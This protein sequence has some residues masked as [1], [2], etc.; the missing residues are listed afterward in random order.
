[1]KRYLNV[2]LEGI[3]E[4]KEVDTI[5]FSVKVYPI[6]V[7]VVDMLESVSNI[8]RILQYGKD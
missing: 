7:I 8:G 3:D 4:F 1:M 2:V 5:G 6:F